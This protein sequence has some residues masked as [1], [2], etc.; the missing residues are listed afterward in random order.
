VKTHP[1]LQLRKP[2]KAI[3]PFSLTLVNE[4]ILAV[5]S[6]DAISSFDVSSIDEPEAKGFVDGHWHDITAL[7]LWVKRA[8][9]PSGFEP[10]VISAGLD[11]TARRWTLKGELNSFSQT[12]L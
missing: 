6:G 7:R 10:M 12:A 5:G 4:P 2:V 1:P 8:K 11:G 9:S 3:L